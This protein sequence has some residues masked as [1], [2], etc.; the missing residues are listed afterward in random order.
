MSVIK[1]SWIDVLECN[2][3]IAE[4]NKCAAPGP[5]ASDPSTE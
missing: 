2:L 3:E 4:V 5:A 1:S